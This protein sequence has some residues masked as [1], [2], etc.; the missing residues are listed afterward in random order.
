MYNY[1]LNNLPE[2]FTRDYEMKLKRK[3][4]P[5]LIEINSYVALKENQNPRQPAEAS[6][7]WVQYNSN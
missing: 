1:R 6:H 4:F 7:C 5:C 3:R 2:F